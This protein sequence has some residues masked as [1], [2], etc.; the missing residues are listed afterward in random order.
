LPVDRALRLLLPINLC[1]LF[2]RECFWRHVVLF[3]KSG[4]SVRQALVG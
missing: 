3:D 2:R 1:D 4:G